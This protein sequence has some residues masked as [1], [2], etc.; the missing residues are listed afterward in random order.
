MAIAYEISELEELAAG[1]E[2]ESNEAGTNPEYGIW[3]YR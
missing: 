1:L 3:W 2:A